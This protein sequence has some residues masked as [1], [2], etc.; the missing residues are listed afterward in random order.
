[1]GRLSAALVKR[2]AKVTRADAFTAMA[3]SKFEACKKCPILSLYISMNTLSLF[4]KGQLKE[5]YLGLVEFLEHCRDKTSWNIKVKGQ[6][7]I[8]TFKSAPEMYYMSTV[9]FTFDR[10]LL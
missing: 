5:H 1:M 6:Y 8:K 9:F 2:V 10:L 3:A 4:F 7:L